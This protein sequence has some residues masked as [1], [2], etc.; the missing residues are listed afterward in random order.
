MNDCDG[1]TSALRQSRT[2]VATAPQESVYGVSLISMHALQRRWASERRKSGTAIRY[3]RCLAH[4][5]I[6]IGNFV[7]RP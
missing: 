2:P 1:R 6:L 3:T 4:P 7:Q 5:S